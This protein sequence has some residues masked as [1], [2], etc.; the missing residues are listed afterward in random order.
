[1]NEAEI[2]DVARVEGY[3]IVDA[4]HMSFTD[5]VRSFAGA[6]HIAGVHGAGLV[7]AVFAPAGA[8]LIE[9]VGDGV[10]PDFYRHLA[11]VGGLSFRRVSCV[12]TGNASELHPDDRRYNDILIDP[13]AALAALKG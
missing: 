7:N 13:E 6:T 1:M 11:D 9:F 8:R 3:E 5:Q 2:Q 12:V 10:A 4:R